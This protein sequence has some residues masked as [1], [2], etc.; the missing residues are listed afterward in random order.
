M[1]KYAH[2]ISCN[3]PVEIDKIKISLSQE[4]IE[5]RTVGENALLAGNLELTGISGASIEVPE[6]KLIQAKNILTKIGYD[7]SENKEDDKYYSYALIAM[8]IA[9]LIVILYMVYLSLS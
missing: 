3:N 7:F 5:T 6:E 8:G 2:L 9:A 4:Q 1:V